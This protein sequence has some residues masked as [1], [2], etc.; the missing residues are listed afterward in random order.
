MQRRCGAPTRITRVSLQVAPGCADKGH[1]GD[2]CRAR[3]TRL[4]I[5]GELGS[6]PAAFSI[7]L[8]DGFA[9]VIRILVDRTRAADTASCTAPSTAL[10]CSGPV[11]AAH[12]DDAASTSTVLARCRPP[13][14]RPPPATTA[15]PLHRCGTVDHHRAADRPL[16]NAPMPVPTASAARCRPIGR[17]GTNRGH[18]GPKSPQ[19]G[20]SRPL[21]R[22]RHGH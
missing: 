12:R 7:D 8:I 18:P 10:V 16:K 2:P 5:P 21:R 11:R 14:E 19:K 4:H 3:S 15:D 9:D 17:I 6:Y 20:R 13:P 1:P 22:L